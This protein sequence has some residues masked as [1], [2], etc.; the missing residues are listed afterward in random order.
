VAPMF[1]VY[2]HL[3]MTAPFEHRRR[4]F[5]LSLSCSSAT[6]LK[7]GLLHDNLSWREAGGNCHSRMV[8]VCC[9]CRPPQGHVISEATCHLGWAD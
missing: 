6:R 1:L 2:R 8:L 5:L 7:Y 3:A 4:F 9:I